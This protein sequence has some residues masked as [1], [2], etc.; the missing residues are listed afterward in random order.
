M[1]LNTSEA[2]ETVVVPRDRKI[3]TKKLQLEDPANVP[4]NFKD[5]LK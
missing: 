2:E 4:T 1:A 3:I 5:Y